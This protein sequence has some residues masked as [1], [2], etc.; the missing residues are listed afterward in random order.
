MR[1]HAIERTF[2]L[3][4]IGCNP[5]GEKFLHIG[6]NID[7]DAIRLRLHD[8]ETQFVVRG[9]DIGDQPPAQP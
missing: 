8:A 4:H 9:V 1:H 2:Q 3:A 7:A 6:G 5:V